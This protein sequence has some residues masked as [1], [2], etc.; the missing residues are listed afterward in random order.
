MEVVLFTDAV[1]KVSG[2]PTAKPT[3]ETPKTT[4][5]AVVSDQTRDFILEQEKAN[6]ST[7][8][9]PAEVPVDP[10]TH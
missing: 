7:T 5:S 6:Y 9:K 10:D 8:P 2:K 3:V 4:D 1:V